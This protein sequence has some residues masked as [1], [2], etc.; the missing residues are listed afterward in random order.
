MRKKNV[1]DMT[2]IEQM[3]VVVEKMCDEY[4]YYRKTLR[5]KSDLEEKCKNCPLGK[6]GV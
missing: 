6:F 4:C 5:Y 1:G 2:I 3:T